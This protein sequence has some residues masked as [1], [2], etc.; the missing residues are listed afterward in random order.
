MRTLVLRLGPGRVQLSPAAGAELIVT[1][2]NDQQPQRRDT[3][4][5]VTLTAQQ[6]TLLGISIPSQPLH[7]QIQVPTD[8][9]RITIQ[10]AGATVL[11]HDVAWA[12]MRLEGTASQLECRTTHL[13]RMALVGTGQSATLQVECL[14]H[15][16]LDGLNNHATV[17]HRT[18]FAIEPLTA[19]LG[20]RIEA[21]AAY[22]NAQHR[23]Q[24]QLNG[25]H[26][27]VEVQHVTH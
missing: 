14:D 4:D 7:W 15:L 23:L 3:P 6:R 19:G 11:S 18:A 8:F 21:P 5:G 16:L 27:V 20:C 13:N 10:A 12:E 17:A 22:P 26:Q 1:C 24:C 25:L 9:N 2:A